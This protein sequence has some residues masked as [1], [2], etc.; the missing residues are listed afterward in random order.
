MEIKFYK[1]E[2][3]HSPIVYAVK[4]TDITV[5]MESRSGGI[6]TALSDQV[7][8]LGGIVYGCALTEEYNAVHMRAENAEERNL[9]RGSKYIQS[10]MSD[11]F[12]HVKEDLQTGRTVLFSGTSCQVAGLSAFLGRDY[13]NLL[14]IDIVCHG[15]P[16][17]LVWHRYLEWQEE[18]VQSKA[19]GVEFRNKY[20][21]GWA[22]HYESIYM[23]NGKQINS[24]IFKKLFYSHY[25]LRPACYKCPYKD[26]IHP[27]NITIGDYWGIDTAA[28]G[29]NDNRGVSLV[30]I[31]D[32]KGKMWFE[33]T[34]G[35]LHVVETR[36]E[37][38]IQ[39]TLQAPFDEPIN[40]KKFWEDFSSK[41][42]VIIAKKYAGYGE[43]NWFMRHIKA[44]V[45]K[46]VNK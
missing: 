45:K 43:W 41:P 46:V 40:R 32:T 42:F 29:F 26:I 1:E 14:M 22:A 34:R 17:P 19:V 28:P 31:N 36:I 20:N 12:C 15:V 18:R 39:P 7:L 11:M 5:R 4:H 44:I 33:K 13:N 21:Y 2:K 25:I 9:M 38:S 35:N 23:L 10:N 24:D 8:N 27:G 6:F 16:S 30:L 3:F 37:D